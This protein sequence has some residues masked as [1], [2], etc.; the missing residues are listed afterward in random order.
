MKPEIAALPISEQDQ[1]AGSPHT[2]ASRAF[3]GCSD[4][5]WLV[6]LKRSVTESVINGVRF[7]R[8]PDPKLQATVVGSSNEQTLDEASAFYAFLKDRSAKIGSPITK[9]S[10]VLDFGCG[11]GRYLRFFWKDV[12]AANLYGVDASAEVLSICRETG[13]P[14]T[15][16]QIEPLGRLPFEDGFFTHVMAYSVFTHL[17]EKVH[18]HWMAE[19]ARVMQPG[20]SFCLTLESRRF[21]DFVGG[22][23]GDIAETEWHRMMSRFAPSV[24][25]FKDAFD[26][27]KVVFMPT[28]EGCEDTY[29]DAVVPLSYI[30]QNW[31]HN[32]RVSEYVDDPAKFWQAVLVVQR[33]YIGRPLLSFRQWNLGN[34]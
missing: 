11:W 31:K 15:L 32:F 22:L 21:L 17:P 25:S 28:N 9:A 1:A 12:D 18:L 5:E 4:E 6:I 29:G 2:N 24:P 3:S 14:G 16:R 10:R 13:V 34:N 20:A 23:D 19:I 8:F 27:G 7:P 26:A 30:E 33:L